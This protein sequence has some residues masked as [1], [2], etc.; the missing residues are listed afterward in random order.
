[1]TLTAEMLKIATLEK[2]GW[3]G[4]SAVSDQMVLNLIPSASANHVSI[5]SRKLE[6]H[7]IT[8]SVVTFF[9]KYNPLD[10]KF[11]LSMKVIHV[12]TNIPHIV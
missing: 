3:W 10:F 1:M 11:N 5:I 9:Q 6:V 4:T 12:N 7:L 2:F 8:F